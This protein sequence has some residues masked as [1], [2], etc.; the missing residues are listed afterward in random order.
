MQ[1]AK[2]YLILH[3]LMATFSLVPVCSKLAG[4]H[5]VFSTSFII[6]YGLSLFILVIYA[7][8]WQ[9]VIKRMP[10]TGA[11]ANKAITIAWGILWGWL[12]FSEKV[13]VTKIVGAL[14]II[15]GIVIYAL[16]DK[17]PEKHTVEKED[18]PH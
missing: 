2:T 3:L 14:V 11:Y 12:I 18:A 8:G 10:L 17:T 15:A 6:Y 7:F 13:T 5:P 4:Q 16:A 9:Q 1:R